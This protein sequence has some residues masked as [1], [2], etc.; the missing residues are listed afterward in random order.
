MPWRF[1]LVRL[2]TSVFTLLG[3]AL[4]VFI[5]LRLLPG[6]EITSTFGTETGVL[7]EKQIE[8][9]RSYYGVDQPAVQQFFSWLGNVVTGNLGFSVRS[10]TSVGSLIG[11]ALPVTV[12]LAL[13]SIL[14]GMIMGVPL[15]VL[16]G[17]RAGTRG[18]A[19]IQFFGLMGLGIPNFVIGTFAVTLFAYWFDYF[20]NARGYAAPWED[21]WLNVQ[22]LVFPAVTLGVAL[23]GTIM[24][25]TRSAF[26]E[27]STQPFVRT[28]RGKGVSARRVRYVHI[29]RNA[30]IPIVTIT[31]IQFGYLLGGTV[32]IEQIFA[33]PGLGRLVLDGIGKR[34]YAVVQ[35]TILVIAGLFVLVNLLVDLLYA[36]LDPRIRNQ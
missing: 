14:V 7:T 32:I 17:A 18:D 9:L 21:P 11:D 19:T 6:D 15:G 3:V 5:V 22:Q 30:S 13:L 36:R 24:R 26:I 25:T 28:A 20:P 10:G 16:S 31:G 8:S 1:A 2:V 27:T 23:S 12:E 33:M 35:S 29:L 34:D 4:L